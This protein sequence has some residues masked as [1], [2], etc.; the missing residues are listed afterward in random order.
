ME[1]KLQ[2]SLFEKYP[3]FFRKPS[4][5][6]NRNP[7]QSCS[8]PIDYW[9]IQCEAGWFDL[10]DRV[11][12]EFE[13]HIEWQIQQCISQMYWPR[14]VQVKEKLGTLR[15]YVRAIE[16]GVPVFLREVIESAV[17]ESALTCEICGNP[18]VLNTSK[19]IRTTCSICE[20]KLIAGKDENYLSNLHELLNSR[21]V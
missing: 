13:K 14:A 10:I 2:A 16:R 4:V 3:R 9:G 21:Q 15:I 18:G 8:G 11:A 1:I 19:W 6:E 5:L 12:A 17:S 20:D 7:N